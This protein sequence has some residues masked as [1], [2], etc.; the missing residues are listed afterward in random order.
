VYIFFSLMLAWGRMERNKSQFQRL[1]TAR[2]PATGLQQWA[3]YG[4]GPLSHGATRVDDGYLRR[5][6]V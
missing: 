4:Y 6:R 5:E 3:R 2:C 1:S